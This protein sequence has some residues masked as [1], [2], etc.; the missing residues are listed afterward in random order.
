MFKPFGRIVPFLIALSLIAG[1]RRALLPPPATSASMPQPPGALRAGLRS[2]SYGISPFP[3]PDWWINSTGSMA[4]RFDSA[5]PSVVWIVGVVNQTY[6][7]LNF[8]APETGEKPKNIMFSYR[9][10]NEEYLSLFDQKGVRVWLQV[11]PAGADIST[12]IDLILRRYASHPCVVGFGVDV[13]WYMCKTCQ[14]GKPVTDAEAQAWVT[15]IRSYNPNYKL[16]LKHWLTEKMPP[17]YRDGVL[18]L[19]DSQGFESLDEMVSEFES[20]GQ[21]FSPAAVGFQYGYEADRRWWGALSEPPG[22][23]GQALIRRIPNTTDL[24]WVDFTAKEMW[25]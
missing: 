8:P 1:C 22:D 12:L 17:T 25:P 15:Q 14:D 21:T 20:W 23:I 3:T 19:D 10:S 11:E 18:F 24:Y 6:S 7:W 9:D 13:E 5:A 2:S 4:A 16:F